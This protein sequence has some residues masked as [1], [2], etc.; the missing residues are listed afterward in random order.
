M[1]QAGLSPKG[2]KTKTIHTHIRTRIHV[3]RNAECT[4]EWAHTYIERQR[5]FAG[6]NCLTLLNLMINAFRFGRFRS[7]Q[8]CALFMN[9]MMVIRCIFCI[10]LWF[11]YPISISRHMFFLVSSRH[12]I[13]DFSTHS[14]SLSLIF[15]LLFNIA[16][17]IRI[18]NRDNH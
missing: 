2:S 4:N 13:L 15:L 3:H 6:E 1:S 14:L 12:P 10:S 11:L 7:A 17:R 5:D 18:R 8:V 9:L 16:S